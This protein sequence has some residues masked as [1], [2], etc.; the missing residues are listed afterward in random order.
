M[1]V[2]LLE[3]TVYGTERVSLS[4][5]MVRTS[6]LVGGSEWMTSFLARSSIEWCSQDTSCRDKRTTDGGQNGSNDTVCIFKNFDSRTNCLIKVIT[7]DCKHMPRNV[8]QF[9]SDI[10]NI[11]PMPRHSHFIVMLQTLTCC[12]VLGSNSCCQLRPDLTHSRDCLVQFTRAYWALHS[13]LS[14][15]APSNVSVFTNDM[16][17]YASYTFSFAF[18]FH[19][20]LALWTKSGRCHLNSRRHAFTCLLCERQPFTV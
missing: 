1:C 5:V 17:I 8:N 3:C 16:S 18:V 10:D 20:L 19:T 11:C 4:Y 6:T 2:L 13:G 12:V 14:T 9:T 7:R 15:C